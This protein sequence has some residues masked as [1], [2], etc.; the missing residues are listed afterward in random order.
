MNLCKNLMIINF[1]KYLILWINIKINK[2]NH[3]YHNLKIK[4]KN[5]NNN[6]QYLKL[7]MIY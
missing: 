6:N 2:M 5:N 4:V 1:K 7:N 3:Y